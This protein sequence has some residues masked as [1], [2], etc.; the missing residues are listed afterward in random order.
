MDLEFSKN[1]T[2]L[3][4]FSLYRYNC[5]Y[6]TM[7]E[8]KNLG[9]NCCDSATFKNNFGSRNFKVQYYNLFGETCSIDSRT[10]AS[11]IS[12]SEKES[13]SEQGT[14]AETTE[15]ESESPTE[16]TTADSFVIPLPPQVG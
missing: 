3:Q 16:S 11:E 9:L 6:Y 1:Y 15:K 12:E 4:E 8:L 7:E 2:I 14:A 13:E 5:I 10:M